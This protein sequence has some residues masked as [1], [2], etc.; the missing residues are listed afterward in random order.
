MTVIYCRNMILMKELALKN[1]KWSR[2]RKI[3]KTRKEFFMTVHNFLFYACRLVFR[4]FA[5]ICS[6]GRE[7]LLRYSHEADSVVL[8]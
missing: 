7:F 1:G 3:E 6:I 5:N 4:K 8:I 2:E